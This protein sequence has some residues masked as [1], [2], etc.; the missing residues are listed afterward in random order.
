M[1]ALALLLLATIARAGDVVV[2][3]LDVGQGDAI[4]IRTPAQKNILI[5]AGDKGSGVVEMLTRLGVD[6]LDLVV[7]SHPHADHIGALESVIRA[8]PPKR[9]L[10]NGL[11]HTTQTYR[12]LMATLEANAGIAYQT[13]QTGQV[14]NLDDGAHLDVLLPDAARRFRDTRSDLN[15]SSVVL[16]LVHGDNC[17]LFTGDAEEPTE[18][19][20]IEANVGRCG[21]LKVAHHGSRHSTIRPLLD[22]LQPKIALISV[23]PGNRYHHPGDETLARLEQAK[24]T[25]Y[26]TDRDG[27]VTLTSDGKAV[28]V[29]TSKHEDPGGALLP[30]AKVPRTNPPPAMPTL[31]GSVDAD[32]ELTPDVLEHEAC[33]FAA[34]RKSDVFHEATCGNAQKI[35]AENLVC[36]A[37]KAAA[38]KAGRR[39]AGCCK[40]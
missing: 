25:V 3:I 15:A 36:Y 8:F 40:P 22:V 35:N 26:R 34:S 19:A 18:R 24:A 27:R 12:G 38:E 28:R 17:M 7:A 37:T 29:T 4:L 32:P 9:Y 31:P 21:V 23:G 14:F 39:P 11:A 13:A 10:D 2:D 1:L 16:K 20:L 33:P 6:H 5:D 30:V